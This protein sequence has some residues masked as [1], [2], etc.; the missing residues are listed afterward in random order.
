MREKQE[1]FL[2]GEHFHRYISHIK[3]PANL[4]PNMSSYKS[5]LKNVI[6]LKMEKQSPEANSEP[7]QAPQTERFAEITIFT[8]FSIHYILDVWQGPE[9]ASKVNKVL[10]QK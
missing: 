9:Y 5:S 7:C 6:S 10:I 2:L 4:R 3:A 1:F 8:I